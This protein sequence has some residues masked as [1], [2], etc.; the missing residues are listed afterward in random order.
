LFAPR[1][2][3]TGTPNSRSNCISLRCPISRA[4]PAAWVTDRSRM[5]RALREPGRTRCEHDYRRIVWFRFDE[6]EARPSRH[7]NC[8]API[9]IRSPGCWRRVSLARDHPPGRIRRRACRSQAARSPSATTTLQLNVSTAS[10]Q[11]F[12][13][14]R[15]CVFQDR[16]SPEHGDAKE[17]W[18]PLDPVTHRDGDAASLF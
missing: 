12:G 6:A 7:A 1:P 18:H 10:A 16:N 15:G 9:Q 17:G 8:F 3:S 11:F 4:I 2:S 5:Q 13:A 14:L